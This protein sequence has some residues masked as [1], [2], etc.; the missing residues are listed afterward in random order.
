MVIG[1]KSYTFCRFL[2]NCKNAK[3]NQLRARR[4][5]SQMQFNLR[6]KR[7][8]NQHSLLHE[9]CCCQQCVVAFYTTAEKYKRTL[10]RGTHPSKGKAFLC[11]LRIW[12]RMHVCR[13]GMCYCCCCHI[14]ENWYTVCGS[15]I[16][17]GGRCSLFRNLIH[18]WSNLHLAIARLTCWLFIC[19][20]RQI[21]NLYYHDSAWTIHIWHTFI[22]FELNAVATAAS[23]YNNDAN[24]DLASRTAVAIFGQRIFKLYRHIHI[25][26]HT[27]TQTRK[28]TS[29]FG[30]HMWQISHSGNVTMHEQIQ[31]AEINSNN[32]EQQ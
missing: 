24:S 13:T 8:E 15:Y 20:L 22:L 1:I 23:C 9:R 27:N 29:N 12:I 6:K 4:K 2:G 5:N 17:C 21:C 30:Q 11:V 28:N 10:F 14:L 16:N 19:E 18:K 31:L 25:H 3:P 26:A 32:R 7:K